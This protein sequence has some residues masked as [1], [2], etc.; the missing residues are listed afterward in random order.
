L[1]GDAASGEPK[2]ANGNSEAVYRAI[3]ENAPD[4]IA[5]VDAEGRI[6]FLNRAFSGRSLQS[7]IGV[8]FFEFVAPPDVANAKAVLARALASDELVRYEGDT[9]IE[10][11]RRRVRARIQRIRTDGG[12]RLIAYVTDVTEHRRT[13]RALA[14]VERELRHAQKMEAIGTLAGGVA[15]DFNNVLSVILSYADGLKADLAERPDL[16]ADIDEIIQ[17]STRGATLSRQLLAFGRRQELAPVLTTLNE[18][19]DGMRKMAR[20]LLR[21]DVELLVDTSAEP[22]S[23]RVDVGQIEQVL[24]NLLVNARDATEEG[25]QIAV[26]IGRSELD[27]TAA[28]RFRVDPGIYASL[29][30]ADTGHGMDA[31][32]QSHIFEPF[33]TTKDDDKG[34]GLGLATVYGIVKQSDG[35]IVVDSTPG[36]GTRFT[37]LFPVVDAVPHPVARADSNVPKAMAKDQHATLLVVEDDQTVRYAMRRILARAG[38]TVMTASDGREGLE[39]AREYDGPIHVI[40]TDIVMP[41]LS[42]PA[43]VERVRE[44]R[45][46]TAVVFMTGY[47]DGA[48]PREAAD[49]MRA[50]VLGKPFSGRDLIDLVRTTLEQG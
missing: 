39:V 35:A 47:G 6:E 48:K 28:D 40:V 16:H 44:L 34:T 23:I 9:L 50:P 32:T 38:F 12:Y 14:Q 11:A 30:V 1:V 3:V 8:S 46:E 20:R 31:E 26:S 27:R 7:V 45:P 4:M 19:V 2:L 13:Q 49:A 24:L 10:G 36:H 15:H 33:F 37:V 42:G 21:E 17:A 18:I 22:E 25:G 43:F 29:S 41:A 5:L